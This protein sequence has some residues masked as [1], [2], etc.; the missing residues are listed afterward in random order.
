M[1]EPIWYILYDGDSGDGKGTPTYY[2]RTTDKEV[3]KEHW[4]KCESSFYSIGKV[5]A[6]TDTKQYTI[7]FDSDWEKL[8]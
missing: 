4:K 8:K 5:V 7:H 6:F 3:A 1:I 2:G